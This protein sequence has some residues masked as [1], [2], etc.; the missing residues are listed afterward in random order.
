MKFRIV[1]NLVL[2]WIG[3]LDNGTQT[4][5]QVRAQF[6]QSPEFGNRVTNVIGAGC[7]H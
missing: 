1:S 6:V 2:V 4:R 5:E 3:Q 7:M